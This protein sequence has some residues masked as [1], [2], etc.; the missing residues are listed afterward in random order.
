MFNQPPIIN[1]FEKAVRKASK[2]L[3]RDFGEIENLQINSKSVGDFV[4]NADINVE[5]SLL[6]TLQKYFPDVTYLSEEKGLIKGNEEMIV[7]DPIDGTTNFIH[8]IPIIGIVVAKIK[9]DEIT[10]GVIFNPISDEF[11][12][13]SKGNGAWCNNK[14]LRVSKR[15]NL[16]TSIIG[17]GIPHSN[18]IEDKHMKEIY[19]IAK[20]SSGIRRMGSAAIDLAYVAAGKLDG[21]WERGL[22]IWDVSSGILLVKE[23][24]GKI[25]ELDGNKWNINSKDILVSNAHIHELMI[26]NLKN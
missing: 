6:E 25:T 11:F 18:E 5:K 8:G 4:T 2:M 20:D 1:I 12:W 16:E 9:D 19:N 17:T 15:H 3:I 22:N 13:A 10:D 14:R 23:A 26:N 21:F 7:I 24:G